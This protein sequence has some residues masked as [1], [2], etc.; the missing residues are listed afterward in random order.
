[1]TKNKFGR[2]SQTL[3]SYKSEKYTN[4]EVEN[5]LTGRE[6]NINWLSRIAHS[7]MEW[8]K[9]KIEPSLKWHTKANLPQITLWSKFTS[10]IMMGNHK[11]NKTVCLQ[12]RLRTK[13]NK[14]TPY[15]KL[16][17]NKADQ[18]HLKAFSCKS[19]VYMNKTQRRKLDDKAIEGIFAGY[20]N[21]WKGY[22]IYTKEKS[23]FL[24][25]TMKFIEIK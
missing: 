13:S 14:I 18:S 15:Q 17:N 11:Q 25:R 9:V 23:L 24:E 20:N 7:K 5:F 4:R 8:W 2:E 3:S 21:R 6:Y 10:E 19:Y 22:R 16:T 1:M 12:N